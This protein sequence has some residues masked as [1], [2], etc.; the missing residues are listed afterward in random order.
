MD[1]GCD[2]D[3]IFLQAIDDAI[4]VD[5]QLPD[6]LVIKFW[7]LASSARKLRKNPDLTQ[8]LLHHIAGVCRRVGRN[9]LG[10]ALNRLEHDETSLF[11]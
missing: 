2:H 3:L 1:Y 7:N 6:L 10:N 4:A 11:C 5:N 8:N 9:V